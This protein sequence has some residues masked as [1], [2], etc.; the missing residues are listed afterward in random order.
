MLHGFK[1]NYRYLNTNEESICLHR[2][3]C[4]CSWGPPFP[5]PWPPLASL[6]HSAQWLVLEGETSPFG[7]LQWALLVFCGEI[8]GPIC[9]GGDEGVTGVEEE[10]GGI[11]WETS[12]INHWHME[13]ANKAIWRSI[14][15]GSLPMC[16]TLGLEKRKHTYLASYRHNASIIYS[17]KLDES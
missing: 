10:D 4:V 3:L 15:I 12:G 5:L 2:P 11:P 6:Y 7:I 8:K 1:R 17:Q 16:K 14:S 13:P 9:G